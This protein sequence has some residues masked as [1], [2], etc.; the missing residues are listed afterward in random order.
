MIVSGVAIGQWNQICKKKEGVRRTKY[1]IIRAFVMGKLSHVYT[2]KDYII[3]YADLNLLVS[4]SGVI[5]TV[6]R[7]KV[8]RNVIIDEKIKKQYDESTTHK[9]NIKKCE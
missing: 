2:T 9:E 4:R 3:R 5:M 1:K 6:W 8:N 7:D